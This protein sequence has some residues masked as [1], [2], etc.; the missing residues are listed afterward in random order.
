MKELEKFQSDDKKRSELKTA[1]KGEKG[2]GKKG[3]KG[4]GKGIVPMEGKG[5]GK[6]QPSSSEKYQNA[7]GGGGW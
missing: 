2:T 3:Q 1:L 5:T 7:K 4:K 6:E